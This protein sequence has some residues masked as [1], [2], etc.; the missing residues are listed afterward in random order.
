MVRRLFLL[1]CALS[2]IGCASDFGK[3]TPEMVQHIEGS[4]FKATERGY[5]TTELVIKPKPPV[6]GKNKANL[7]IHDYEANDTPGLTIK[8]V[9]KMTNSDVASKEKPLIKDAGRGLY[10]I[11]NIDIHSSGMWELQMT[12][13]GP[14]MSDKV[15]LELPEIK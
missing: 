6:V 13:S 1:V 10:L 4:I 3:K 2:L 8:I 5:Y 15:T 14:R 11:E 12:I 7:I 9:P